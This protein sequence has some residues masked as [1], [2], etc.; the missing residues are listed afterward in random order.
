MNLREEA[1]T[2][3]EEF[4]WFLQWIGSLQAMW[5]WGL[6]FLSRH[7]PYGNWKHKIEYISTYWRSKQPAG[8]TIPTCEDDYI[9]I[10]KAIITQMFGL[11]GEDGILLNALKEGNKDL[12]WDDL[13]KQIDLG[14]VFKIRYGIGTDWSYLVPGSC[15]NLFDDGP[16]VFDCAITGFSGNCWSGVYWKNDESGNRVLRSGSLCFPGPIDIL[17]DAFPKKEDSSVTPGA[18]SSGVDYSDPNDPDPPDG[19]SG[20]DDSQDQSGEEEE[21]EKPPLP[22]AVDV[23]I[24]QSLPEEEEEGGGESGD[25]GGG[26]GESSGSEEPE[27]EVVPEFQDFV[28]DAW[29]LI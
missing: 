2:L 10:V 26:G 27:Q 11:D 29:P 28:L 8:S 4:E 18:D 22:T 9:R 12:T 21:E 15:V 20:S 3:R 1:E 14:D 23:A 5:L 6:I 24:E 17:V 25:D 16:M 13:A 7:G 19:N